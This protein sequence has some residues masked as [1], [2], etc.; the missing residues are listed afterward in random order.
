VLATRRTGPD[1][2]YAFDDLLEGSYTL[3]A[4]GYAPVA[5]GLRITPGA[6]VHHSVT[7][8]ANA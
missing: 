8:G 5:A 7:L 1:G 6:E 4:S 3:I 2:T